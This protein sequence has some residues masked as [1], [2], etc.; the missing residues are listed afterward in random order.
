MG[1]ELEWILER[2]DGLRFGKLGLTGQLP[3]TSSSYESPAFAVEVAGKRISGRSADLEVVNIEHADLGGGRFEEIAHCR[4]SGATQ[5]DIEWHVRHYPGEPVIEAWVAVRNA[6]EEPVPVQRLDSIAVGLDTNACELLSFTG[7]WGMEFE[8]VREPLRGRRVLETLRGRSSHGPHPWFALIRPDDAVLCGAVAWSGNWVFRFEPDQVGDRHLLSGGLHDNGFSKSL[9]PGERVEA[10]PVVLAL[11][12]DGDLDT[13]SIPLARL[14]RKFW[15][16]R[17]QLSEH[18]PVE[19]NHWW[20]YED[21]SIDESVFRANVDVAADIGVEVCTLDA[22]WFGPADPDTNWV[23]VRGDWDIVNPA[24]FPS[25]IRALAD[26]VHGKGMRFGIWCEIEALGPKA[27]LAR[28]LPDLPAQ[29]DGESLG[30]VCFGNPDAAE[31]AFQTLDRLAGDYTADWIK[32]DFNLDPGLGCDRTDHGHGAGDGLF[33]HYVGYYRVLERIRAAHPE[34]VLENC[35][36]GG[37]RID[38]GMQ[39]Q[40]HLT[41][42]SDPDWPEHGL[43]ALWAAS[44]LLPPN[45]LLHWGYS[46]WHGEHRCQLFDPRDPAL[47]THQVD[48]YRRVAMVGATGL[49]WKLP[50]LPAAVRDRLHENNKVYQDVVR[51]F[52]R[53]ADLR[54]LTEQPMRFGEGSRWAGFQ[55]SRP[56][57]PEHLVLLFRLPGGEP[58][59]PILL[60]G[61]DPDRVYDVRWQDAGDSQTMTGRSLMTDGLRRELPEE[62]AELVLVTG[63]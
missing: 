2:A 42:L 59:R 61:L 3:W 10:P 57:R 35:S 62:G 51:P 28:N 23:D 29:R 7:S 38:L 21:H 11:G 54:R 47:E 9:A 50:E 41:F 12:S 58:M 48:Y 39:R 24:R 31:W 18:L 17:N 53:T 15:A 8:P 52:V 14:G 19:W 56:D 46:E 27:A 22:G 40:T 16:P 37:L 20:P 33:E 13:T 25:G 44:L 26:Y 55:Y 36:S 6:G 30:Y 60:R 34:L 1:A 45:Q 63:R 5:L 4:Y 43:Q 49:A 32:L